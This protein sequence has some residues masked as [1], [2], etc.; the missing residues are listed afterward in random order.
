MKVL[1]KILISLLI[2][3]VVT[4]GS[5]WLFG[6]E[7]AGSAL[8]MICIALGGYFGAG[9][10]GRQAAKTDQYRQEWLSRRKETGQAPPE[11]SPRSEDPQ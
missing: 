8:L 9:W 5:T 1:L 7:S 11:R 10:G 4:F 6:P 2:I 3:A